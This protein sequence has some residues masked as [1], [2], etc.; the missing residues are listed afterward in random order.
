MGTAWIVTHPETDIDREGRLHGNLDGALDSSGQIRAKQIAKEMGGKPVKRILSSPK[1][2]ARQTAEAISK[3]TG[4]KVHVL[5]DLAPWNAGSLSGAKVA[6][7][8]P[9][10]DH[11]AANPEKSPRGGEPK[12]AFLDRFKRVA[13]MVRPG[14]VI[15]GHS[16]HALAW[17]YA[18]NGGDSTKV[19]LVSGKSG[20]V[21][22]VSVGAS[23][24]PLSALGRAS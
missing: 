10:I 5:P 9:V 7:V 23:E 21:K 16:Q 17:N 3:T 14:D 11:Y 18:K 8:K 1:L 20:Q 22:P 24:M 12:Q 15:A 2:R 19:P 4:A 6:S 13:K